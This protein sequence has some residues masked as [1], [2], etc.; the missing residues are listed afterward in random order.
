MKRFPFYFFALIYSITFNYSCNSNQ[1]TPKNLDPS[2]APFPVFSDF[3]TTQFDQFQLEAD[4][5]TVNTTKYV[6]I[7]NEDHAHYIN[8]K[9][10]TEIVL[11][12]NN[13]TYF[14]VFLRS[15]RYL[16]K[17][18]E[19]ID[20][21][22]LNAKK[23]IQNNSFHSFDFATSKIDFKLTLFERT[24]FIRLHFRTLKKHE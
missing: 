20:F 24:N 9:D 18:Q 4:L 16:E 2:F 19:L 23:Y 11:P 1:S 10:S 6:L 15:H 5:N 21:F 3:P 14:T 13:L 8:L 17:H 12:Q 7:S 22:A